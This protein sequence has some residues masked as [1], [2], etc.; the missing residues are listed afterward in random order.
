MF[1][2]TAGQVIA[3]DGKTL[4]NSGD[5]GVGKAAIPMVTTT[6]AWIV[7][8]QLLGTLVFRAGSG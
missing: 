2:V 8:T 3:I 6:V 1:E 7:D 4:R 5:Q